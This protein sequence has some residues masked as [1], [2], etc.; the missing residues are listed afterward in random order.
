MRKENSYNIPWIDFFAHNNVIEVKN[1]EDFD[2]FKL[3]LEHFDLVSILL[4]LN[5]YKDWQRLALL[6]GGEFRYFLFEY[7]NSKGLTWGNDHKA[8]VEWYGKE[9]IPASELPFTGTPNFH[10]QEKAKAQLSV[11]DLINALNFLEEKGL[12]EEGATQPLRTFA[13]LVRTNEKC[14]RCGATLYKSDLPQY[15]Y[16][17]TDCDENF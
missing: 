6:N 13:H 14:P 3:F 16:V 12:G 4:G 9:P 8:A 1:Q 10:D 2:K 15:D 7:D 5:T 11:T 17:C